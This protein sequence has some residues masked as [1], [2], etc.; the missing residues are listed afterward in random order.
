MKQGANY[1]HLDK[2]TLRHLLLGFLLEKAGA[3]PIAAGL[4]AVGF[5]L[6]EDRLKHKFPA[7][8]PDASRDSKRNALTDVAA[9]VAGYYVAGK[10]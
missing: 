1:S 6:V 2:Y 5:E 4:I 10:V 3:T 7:I 8:F 9:A